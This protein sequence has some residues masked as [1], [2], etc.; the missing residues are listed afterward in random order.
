MEIVEKAGRKILVVLLFLSFIF[1]GCTGKARNSF[2][3]PEETGDGWSVTALEDAGLK[4]APL[5]ELVNTLTNADSHLI[6]SILIAKDGKLVFEEYFRGRKFLGEYIQFT[7]D[8]LHF[9]A[10]VSKSV[11]SIAFGI[12]ADKGL[13]GDVSQSIC[14]F[15]SDH[16]AFIDEERKEIQVRHLLTMSSGLSWDEWSY[17]YTDDRNDVGMLFKQSDPVGFIL[18][19]PLLNKPGGRFF[20]NSGSTNLMGQIVGDRSGTRLDRFIDEFLFTPLGITDYLWD[21]LSNDMV[22]ASGGLYLRPRDMA[23]IGQLYL[24][25]GV[26]EGKR[27]VSEEWV[28][29]STIGYVETPEGGSYGYQW[30]I[31]KFGRGDVPAFSARGWGGQYIYVI[32]SSRMVV[33]INGGGYYQSPL[34][35]DYSIINNYILKAAGF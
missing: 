27:I 24:D 2:H 18:S 35:S 17:P 5:A 3:T 16:Q 4:S 6:H 13:I 11:T 12:A 31:S 19:K 33:V 10:S 25:K 26:W 8:N 21:I 30:W 14:G 34:F 7:R 20:Y 1:S 9:Q 23:K 15:F 32:P 29:A 22:F 28:D